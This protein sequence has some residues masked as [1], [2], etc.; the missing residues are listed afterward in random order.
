MQ[1]GYIFSPGYSQLRGFG[2]VVNSSPGPVMHWPKAYFVH[3][4][5][6]QDNNSEWKFIVAVAIGRAEGRL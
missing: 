6:L 3:F 5:V 2:I 4:S 1:R